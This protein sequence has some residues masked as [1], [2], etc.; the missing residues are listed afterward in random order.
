MDIALNFASAIIGGLIVLIIQNRIQHKKDLKVNNLLRIIPS[1]ILELLAPGITLEFVKE[2]LGPPM[3]TTIIETRFSKKYPR[4]YPTN[5]YI[6]L[7]KNCV[8][9]ITSQHEPVVNS[10]TIKSFDDSIK[11]SKYTLEIN[12]LHN[13]LNSSI[14]T[15]ALI[16]QSE[17]FIERTINESFF[18]L[19]YFIPNPEYKSVTLWGD[20]YFNG[21]DETILDKDTLIGKKVHTICL[22]DAVNDTAFCIHNYEYQI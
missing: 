10:I 12:L 8:I 3:K 15:K 2:I 17:L 6:Y 16:E 11:I 4:G 5:A 9:K 14:V 21:Y 20:G 7:F 13:N 1:D 19:K 22:S 18:G